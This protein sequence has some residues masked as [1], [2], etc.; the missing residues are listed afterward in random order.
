[1]SSPSP[2][3]RRL[4]AGPFLF[5]VGWVTCLVAGLA[6][7]LRYAADP[8]AS[9][10]APATMGAAGVASTGSPWP[11]DKFRLLVFLH[12]Q[13]P[14]SR[15]TVGELDRIVARAGS[16]AC[17]RAFFLSDPAR[18][19]AWTK[20]ATWRSAAAIPGVEVIADPSGLAAQAYGARTSGE[21]LLYSPAGEL[22]FHGGITAARGHAGQNAGSDTIVAVLRGERALIAVAP[23]FGCALFDTPDPMDG[24]PEDRP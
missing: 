14:C 3:R 13:C 1:M 5:F 17:I 10:R 24:A 22:V 19:E 6:F 2:R 9:A 8:G 20:S 21:T 18:D 23:V 12:P 7:A 4:R 15:A 11:A 16:R